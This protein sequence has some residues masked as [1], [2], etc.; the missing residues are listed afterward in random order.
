MRAWPRLSRPAAQTSRGR[1]LGT[2]LL[3]HS[4]R[5]TCPERCSREFLARRF[6]RPERLRQ[7]PPLASLPPARPLYRGALSFFDLT[8]DGAGGLSCRFAGAVKSERKIQH[9]VMIGA[10]EVLVGFEHEVERWRLP[11]P[12]AAARRIGGRRI[13]VERC[14]EHPHMAGLHTVALLP[15]GRAALACSA[16]DAVLLLDLESGRVEASL[17]MPA[18]L[19]GFNYDLGPATDLRAHYIDD[20]Q[21]TT[22]LNAAH[23]VDGGRQLAV[24]TLIPGAVG[25]FDLETGGYRELVRGFVGCHGARAG[26]DGRIYFS[27]SPRGELVHLGCDGRVESRFRTGSRWLHDAVQLAGDWYAFALSDSNELRIC[28]AASGALLYRRRFR[29]WPLNRGF[30]LAARW[31]AWL[32]NSTQALSFHRC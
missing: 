6:G 10:A 21:Q 24:S 11:A 4:S 31:P 17:R 27:D 14:Y 25:L 12:V 1:R 13:V 19:Y 3:T 7:L 5:T 9:A 18:D 32:G 28:D 29:N 23:P 30:P 15:D 2:L 8:V 22:H 26:A 16:P 20:E